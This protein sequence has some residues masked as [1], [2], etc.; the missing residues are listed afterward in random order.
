[1]K[2]FLVLFFVV[3]SGV[4]HA[5]VPSKDA[6]LKAFVKNL[7]ATVDWRTLPAADGLQVWDRP[8]AVWVP[9]ARLSAG[10]LKAGKGE[11][12]VRSL[13][14]ATFAKREFTAG[15]ILPAALADGPIVTLKSA[16]QHRYSGEC[17]R[18]KAWEGQW[19][20]IPGDYLAAHCREASVDK[21]ECTVAAAA[22]PAWTLVHHH[23][24][25]APTVPKGVMVV[26]PFGNPME[27][28]IDA[29]AGA[30]YY[31]GVTKENGAW[32]LQSFGTDA[33]CD[34]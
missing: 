1:M 19:F 7:A 11:D 32:K 18:P 20:A 27:R 17:E 21:K 28:M 8:G 13:L 24:E 25:A 16:K 23:K 26:D 3:L 14:D 4:A 6:S 29:N 22:T 2:P 15:I 31:F 9:V 34:A 30:N 10:D 12:H 5:Q 33:D